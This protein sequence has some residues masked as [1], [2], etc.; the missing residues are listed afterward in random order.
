MLVS[1]ELPDVLRGAVDPLR[2]DRLGEFRIGEGTP[3]TG[4]H[5]T[6]QVGEQARK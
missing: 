1:P 5:G 2:R 3:A 4:V 6:Y